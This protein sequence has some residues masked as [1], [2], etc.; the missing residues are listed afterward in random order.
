M[1]PIR[2]NRFP[3]LTH[4]INNF[5]F[6]FC[7]YY[8][9]LP[10]AAAFDTRHRPVDRRREAHTEAQHCTY[11]H[12][13]MYTVLYSTIYASVYGHFESRVDFVE[14]SCFRSPIIFSTQFE[15]QTYSRNRTLASRRAELSSEILFE[16][17]YYHR[18]QQ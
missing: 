9:V 3:Y 12:T 11:T 1:Y 4:E 2:D 18:R 17:V 16:I 14:S 8:A 13:Y 5:R 6:H 7:G 10:R 15:Y